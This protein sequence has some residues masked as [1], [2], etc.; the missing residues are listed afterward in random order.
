M[1]KTKRI[2]IRALIDRTQLY[3]PSETL[4]LIED[5][6]EFA[7]QTL[8]K[9]RGQVAEVELEHALRTAIVVAE[10]QLDANCIAAALLHGLP[11]KCDMDSSEASKRFG[12]QTCKLVQ[13]LAKLEKVSLPAVEARPKKGVDLEGQAESLRKML[14]ALS[15]DIRVIFIKLADRLQHMRTL[16]LL[17]PSQ[18]RAIAQETMEIYAPIAHRL[19][20]LQIKWQ[21]EDLAF[22]YLEPEAYREIVRFVRAGRKEREEYI[23]Q[24]SKITKAY[25]WHKEEDGK[26]CHPRQG[27]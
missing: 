9:E 10:L 1:T 24:V 2:D 14:M 16:K 3:L 22:R 8:E 21:L 6:Y 20:I 13:E 27:A 25:L 18:R 12:A 5:A 26:V 11:E 17:P 15:E 4:A 23:A 7:S 19:G